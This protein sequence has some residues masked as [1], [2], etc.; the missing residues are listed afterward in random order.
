MK[1]IERKYIL[2]S[3]PKGLSDGVEISQGYLSPETRVRKKGQ[4]F[5]LTEKIGTGLVREE[6][7]IQI[8]ETLF[9]IL[10]KCTERDR[11]EKTRYKLGRWEVDVFKDFELVLA[12]IEL[13][14]ET[15]KVE[16]PAEF[17]G[18]QIKEVTHDERFTNA[19]L[20]A[21]GPPRL[22][23]WDIELKKDVWEDSNVTHHLR[24]SKDG[25][26]YTILEKKYALGLE[27]MRII[28]DF[29][30]QEFS[31]QSDLEA[32]AHYD[33]VL[34]GL[35]DVIS[36]SPI[37]GWVT[38]CISRDSGAD[39]GG[40]FSRYGLFTVHE[41]NSVQMVRPVGL[42]HGVFRGKN[43]I[44]EKEKDIFK[45]YVE[46][47]TKGNKEILSNLEKFDNIDN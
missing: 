4:E 17:V 27:K 10:W 18:M 1:E 33:N 32:I 23:K 29:Y 40:N 16:F 21:N 22:F 34:S 37:V 20:A 36:K 31:M 45:K 26:K 7:E 13:V 19:V 5:F 3:C 30:S 11:V 39:S 2:I 44:S 43:E 9:N 15:E 25:E 35:M 42:Y 38:S 28:D 12:E 6:T 41:D 24:L 46:F 47:N 14:Y 8:N